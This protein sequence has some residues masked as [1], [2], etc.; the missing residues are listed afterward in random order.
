MGV[1]ANVT[2]T[3]KS[4]VPMFERSPAQGAAA[5]PA[6]VNWTDAVLFVQLAP[7]PSATLAATVTVT[8]PG[9]VHVNVG[10]APVA[11][12][13]VPLP[14]PPVM[15]HEKST[16]EV[17]PLLSTPWACRLIAPPTFAEVGL[18]ETP[19]TAAQ[20]GASVTIPL[21]AAE[22]LCPASTALLPHTTSTVTGVVT[23]GVMPNVAEP[24][25]S[26]PVEV[27]AVSVI[28]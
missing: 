12:L 2:E 7:P 10:E 3:W 24:E 11:P 25:Q 28:V 22:P 9:L 17:L 19:V 5:V 6:H 4:P 26:S 21:T 1:V 27:I 8:G 15:A 20:G 13:S 23:L 18:A 16:S 14:V